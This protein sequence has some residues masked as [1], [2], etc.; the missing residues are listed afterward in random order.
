[1]N[2]ILIIGQA[3][4]A[5]AQQVPYDSTMLYEW[6]NEVGITKDKAQEMFEFEALVDTFPGKGKN[7]H[8]A[9]KKADIDEYW[10]CT[11]KAKVLQADKV[12]LLGRLANAYVSKK[13]ENML[14][15]DEIKT[16]KYLCTMHPSKRNRHLYNKYKKK[17]N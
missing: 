11:L 9:P 10:Q 8:F 6:L 13:V 15:F 7:G 1:M 2:K 14:I 12:W 5:K 4:P 17:I 16:Q 3:P